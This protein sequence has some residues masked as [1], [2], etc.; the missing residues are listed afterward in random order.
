MWAMLSSRFPV[1]QNAPYAAKRTR[2]PMISRRRP[3]LPFLPSRLRSPKHGTSTQSERAHGVATRLAVNATYRTSRRRWKITSWSSTAQETPRAGRRYVKGTHLA[4]RTPTSSPH[5]PLQL[6][7]AR[8]RMLLVGPRAF[9]WQ[10]G[11][12]VINERDWD[13]QARQESTLYATYMDRMTGDASEH[14]DRIKA[15]AGLWAAMSKVAKPCP[16]CHRL[17]SRSAGCDS[18]TCLCG[19]AFCYR[20]GLD[21]FQGCVCEDRFQEDDEGWAPNNDWEDDANWL[22]GWELM[23]YGWSNKYGKA[24]WRRHHEVRLGESRR[25]S[26]PVEKALVPNKGPLEVRVQVGGERRCH[27]T[28]FSFKLRGKQCHVALPCPWR[29]Q[30]RGRH[31]TALGPEI[32]TVLPRWEWA[33]KVVRWERADHDE[34]ETRCNSSKRRQRCDAGKVGSNAQ[35]VADRAGHVKAHA[36]ST[37]ARKHQRNFR[38]S[39]RSMAKAACRSELRRC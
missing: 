19:Q 9:E 25:A 15:D 20:C 27:V 35:R 38:K 5:A 12:S 18:M 13:Q 26:P 16:R 14:L 28:W 29:Q 33:E 21:R 23:E 31:V 36:K 17:V 32:K 2:A 4:F 10:T 22:E 37:A 34:P 30:G 7:T 3:V 6:D 11:P 8:L 1:V 24:D 39:T